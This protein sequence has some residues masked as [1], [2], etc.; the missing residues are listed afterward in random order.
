M[1]QGH[2]RN[3]FTQFQP[4]TELEQ[5]NEVPRTDEEPLR[6]RSSGAGGALLQLQCDV[7]DCRVGTAAARLQQGGLR[8]GYGELSQSP[9]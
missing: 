2:P 5:W 3:I 8:G 1:A 6:V 4:E 7:L 9:P